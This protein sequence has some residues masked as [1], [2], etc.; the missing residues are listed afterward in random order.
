VSSVAGYSLADGEGEHVAFSEAEFLVKAAADT[1][2]GAFTVIEERDPLDTPR[3]VHAHED[4]LFIV[5]EGEHVFEIGDREFAAGPG[6][7]VFAPRGVPHAHRR[8][9]A[10]TGRFLTLTSP[11]GFERFFHELAAAEQSAE[12][13]AAAY[14]RVAEKYGIAWG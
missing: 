12:P 2:G 3:H 5:L 10:R 11:A 13:Q 9:V 8:A 7:V 14:E 6:S 1:T 4:E